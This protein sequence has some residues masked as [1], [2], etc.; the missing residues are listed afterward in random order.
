M[1]QD[2]LS[3]QQDNAGGQMC[4]AEDPELVT[5]SLDC[6]FESTEGF[7]SLPTEGSGDS[8]TEPGGC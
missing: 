7:H 3:H 1:A 8:C 5:A 2:A 4:R 6:S